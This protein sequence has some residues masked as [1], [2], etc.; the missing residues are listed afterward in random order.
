M[1][2]KYSPPKRL[3]CIDCAE[4][5]NKVSYNYTQK[6]NLCVECFILRQ[7]KSVGDDKKK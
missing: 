1:N 5:S 6:V 2:S 4:F 7:I 3:K